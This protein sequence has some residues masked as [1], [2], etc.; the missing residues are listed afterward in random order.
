[1]CYYNSSCKGEVNIIN[2]VINDLKGVTGINNEYFILVIISIIIVLSFK[3][4]SKIVC[5]MYSLNGHSSRNVFK[6]N[7]RMNVI[8]NVI[9][10][11]SI[12]MLWEGH[13][14]NIVTIISFVSA[15]ATIALREV[16]LNL[17]AGLYIKVSKP[18]VVE[19][20]IEIGNVKGDVVL[21]SSMSFKVLELGDRLNGEQ[22]SGIIVNIPNSKIFSEPLKNYTTAFKY[23]WSEMVVGINFDADIDESK[24][25]IYSIVSKN[26]VIK[27]IPKKM[28]RAIIEACGT[29]RIYYNN[30]K[31]IIYTEYKDDHIELTIRFLVHPKKERN[32]INDLWIDIIKEAQ[33]G[34]IDLYK[35]E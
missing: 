14:K 25:K 17:I 28:D 3:V 34:N 31:P 1:M 6:F 10:F 9:I 21:I 33:K 35:K 20:R 30:L 5:K 15:G 2:N 18:F 13:L 19:D 26:E 8:M 23:I 16:I 11:F 4:I 12:F 29:Y 32:V 24:K 22:S 7:Q 27:A